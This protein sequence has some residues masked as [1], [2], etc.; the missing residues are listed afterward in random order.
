MLLSPRGTNPL[1]L[2]DAELD[3]AIDKPLTALFTSPKEGLE[4]AERR[5][6]AGQP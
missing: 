5:W 4:D 6:V 2:L 3:Q 1:P